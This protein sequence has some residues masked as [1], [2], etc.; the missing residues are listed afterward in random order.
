MAERTP[1]LLDVDTGI[2][3][4]LALLYACASPEAELLAVT[5]VAGNVEGR[6][7]ARTRSRCWSSPVAGTCRSGSAPRRRSLKALVT[8]P[9]DARPAGDRLSRSC[10]RR[11]RRWSQATPRT[12]SWR[13]RARRPGEI[14]LVT[15]GPLTNVALALQREP[16]LPRSA[17][18]AWS[19]WAAPIDPRATPTPTAEWNVHVDPDAAKAMFA[20]FGAEIAGMP[21]SSGRWR[22][23]ST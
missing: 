12:G 9:E 21:R 14:T 13:W 11:A 18:D 19:S 8:T 2:D 4:A 17:S 10:R 20:A 1:L 23:A 3:D 7:V 16:A 15:L 22:W 5:C 6:Q